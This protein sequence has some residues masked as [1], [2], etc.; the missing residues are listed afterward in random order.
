MVEPQA[1]HHV[2]VT[3]PDGTYMVEKPQASNVIAVL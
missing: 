3:K 2:T 1:S